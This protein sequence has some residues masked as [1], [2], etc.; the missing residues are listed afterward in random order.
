VTAPAERPKGQ[1]SRARA[2][3]VAAAG[4]CLALWVWAAA[5]AARAG[6]AGGPRPEPRPRA[7]RVDV[8][9]AD[10]GALRALPGIGRVLSQRIAEDR[11]L[12][13]PF[14]GPGDL[15]RVRGVTPELVRR[16]EALVEFGPGQEGAAGPEPREAPEA[17][18]GGRA[19]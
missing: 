7:A 10:E 4:L 5:W 13:G 9:S 1:L 8:N 19:P 16:I 17:P 2:P 6:C 15:A 18:E 14:R 11:G 12:R 3:Y